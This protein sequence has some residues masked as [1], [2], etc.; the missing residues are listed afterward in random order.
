MRFSTLRQSLYSSFLF[1]AF[2]ACG[3]AP[4]NRPHSEN[5]KFDLMLSS[6]LK[7][8][9]PTISCDTLYVHQSNYVLLDAREA[10]EYN[11][12]HLKGAQN[13]GYDKFEL[14]NLGNITKNTPIVVYCSIGYRSEK[15]GE[16]L[17]QQ[18]YTNVQNLYG[19][20][21]EWTNKG[22]P[23]VD[24]QGAKTNLLHTYNQTWSIWAN[25]KKVKKVF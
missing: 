16:K 5:K 7:F 21:F 1:M 14:K 17:Q 18:G 11:I 10:H 24:N 15:I 3:Q 25:G 4:M 8:S 2:C 22:F 20:I 23:I 6:V 13:I 19:S 9:V 12:S